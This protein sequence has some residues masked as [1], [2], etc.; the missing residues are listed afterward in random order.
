MASSLQTTLGNVEA[1]LHDREAE[2]CLAEAW[3]E[4][5]LK[6]TAW[7]E[8]AG[9]FDGSELSLASGFGNLPLNL[10]FQLAEGLGNFRPQWLRKKLGRR[11]SEEVLQSASSFAAKR[12][13]S[14]SDSFESSK[15]ALACSFIV[16]FGPAWKPELSTL[17]LCI[18]SF[19]R[20]AW[21]WQLTQCSLWLWKLSRLSFK[22]AFCSLMGK[23]LASWKP[24]SELC[25]FNS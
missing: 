18:C 10:K 21:H 23:K 15:P 2:E 13:S 12:R 17:Q 8:P 20:A 24:T 6:K 25:S 16:N 5:E 1:L 4:E 14:L 9:R 3:S 7:E 11:A 22:A 19:Q